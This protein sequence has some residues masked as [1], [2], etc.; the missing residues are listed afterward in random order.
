[1]LPFFVLFCVRSYRFLT[2]N[3]LCYFGSLKVV[4]AALIRY[5]SPGSR[6]HVL[7]QGILEFIVVLVVLYLARHLMKPFD[8]RDGLRR[9]YELVVRRCARIFSLRLVTATRALRVPV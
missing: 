4:P 1:M 8:Q 5:G 3:S 9:W 6:V 2:P 7:F